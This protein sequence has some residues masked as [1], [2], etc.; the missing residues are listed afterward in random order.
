MGATGAGGVES[1]FLGA[2]VAASD[3]RITLDARLRE[4]I[5]ADEATVGDAAID[6][7]AEPKPR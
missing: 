6:G 4:G 3:V 2:A 1:K 7:F 5:V